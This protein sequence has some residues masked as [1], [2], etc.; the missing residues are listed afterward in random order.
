MLYI[1]FF[2]D[3]IIY[4][5]YKNIY[6]TTKRIKKMDFY[7]RILADTGY[8]PKTTFWQDFTIAD[9]F[10]E[11]AV[12][13]TYNRAFKEWK[14]NIEYLTELVMILNWKIF[15]LYDT[16]PLL[17]KIY[18]DLWQKSDT[19]CMDNLTGKELEYYLKTTD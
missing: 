2:Y 3:R 1:W 9:A 16:N 7:Q 12:R 5:R 10:G 6:K 4:Y 15:Q 11:K 19:Y 18:D 8:Q 13:D 14:S 17:A